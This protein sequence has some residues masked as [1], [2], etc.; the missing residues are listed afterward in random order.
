MR[1]RLIACLL[2]SLFSVSLSQT[3]AQEPPAMNHPT[4]KSPQDYLNAPVVLGPDDKAAFLAAPAGFDQRREG[5]AH[6]KVEMVEYFSTTVGN[7]RRMLI[8]TPPGYSLDKRY[9]VLYL[10]HG[11]GGD[12]MEWEKNG[13][14]DVILDN[15][16]ADRKIVP[17]I[18]V[19]PNGRA[20]PNDRAE[21]D[22]YSHAPAFA[23]FQF[24]LIQ[25]I[26]PFVEAHYP[27]KKERENRAL[28]GLSMGGGQA[29]D[30]GL[31]NLDRFAWV[32]GFS[33][34]PNTYP[35]EKLVLNPAEATQKL[36]L[37]WL[38]CGDQD[39]LINIS[40]GF[41]PILK[42][43][44]FRIS[45]M[46]M[47]AGIPG[48][49]GKTICISFPSI[50]FGKPGQSRR[51]DGCDPGEGMT[52]TTQPFSSDCYGAGAGADFEGAAVGDRKDFAGIAEAGRIEN[53]AEVF[54][55]AEGFGREKQRHVVA[56][57]HTDPVFTGQCAADADAEF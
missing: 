39:G 14:P 15:L 7:K 28:A 29:L 9:P 18:V 20:Q 53:R 45:G 19:L 2:F 47:P 32:G 23:A 49:F 35:P 56:L 44:T 3:A 54:H 11:I 43:K 22:I 24:D 42:R 31:G 17:M 33:P 38:S 26:I 57:F 48:R 36:K 51:P 55:R 13:A 4:V 34:A 21:G 52:A 6:G 50:F 46:S 16:T 5:I 12:E 27:I 41:T 25:D 1:C 37:L 40:Q 30:F 10:L 8:Y